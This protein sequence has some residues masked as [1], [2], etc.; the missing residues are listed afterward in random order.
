MLTTDQYRIYSLVC[1]IRSGMS[2]RR[3]APPVADAPAVAIT[4]RGLVRRFG[5]TTAVDGVDL[6]VGRGRDLRVPRA[7]RGRQVD[8]GPDAVHPAPPE[9]R[10]RPPWPA[11]T[12]WSIPRRCGSGSAWPSRRRPSTTARPVGSCS[13]S[14]VGSTGSGRPEIDA[15]WPT[16]ST[17]STSAGAIDRRI[18]T[19]SGGMK[20]R[21]DLAAALIHNPQVLFLDEPTTGLDPASRASVWAEVRRLNAEL[22]MT[23]FLTTQYLEEA[24]ALADRVG[25]ISGGRLVAEGSPDALKHSVGQDVIVAE[26]DGDDPGAL[27]RLRAPPRRRRRVRRGGQDHHQH[28]RR[29][30]GAQPDRPLARRGATSR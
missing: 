22:G 12:W 15:G 3:S 30:G 25:I 4:T 9:R 13:C 29:P 14:R 27:A 23:I 8:P 20:R 1:W 18:G 17:W 11:T 7:Q 16:C 5:T 2:T 26:V 19:Y 28:L 10:A 6:D 24:D 21:L